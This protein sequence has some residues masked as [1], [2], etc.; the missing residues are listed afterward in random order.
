VV[1]WKLALQQ[2]ISLVLPAV[3]GQI[4][5][6]LASG[7]GLEEDERGVRREDEVVLLVWGSSTVLKQVPFSKIMVWAVGY[8]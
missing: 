5:P 4:Q 8:K 3:K 6:R 2:T 1:A 7:L